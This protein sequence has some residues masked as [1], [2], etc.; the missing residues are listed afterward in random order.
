[1]ARIELPSG[2]IGAENLP[3]TKRILQNIWNNGDG[4]G[5]Q[6]PGI[7]SIL[8]TTGN[9]A[10]GIFEWNDSLYKV[11]SQELRKIT[12]VTT[13]V[14]TLVGT[15]A[16]SQPIKFAI[17]FNTATIVV[18]QSDGNI[19]TLDK[20]DVLTKIWDGV[21]ESGNSNFV[22]C[23]DLTHVDSR[24][25]YI[26][27][28]GTPAFV[29]D[30]G[31]AG[32]VQ[33]DSFFDAEELPDINNG[34]FRD[35]NNR[36][37][38]AGE[39]SIQPFTN[40]GADPVTFAT[41]SGGSIPVG[42][43]GGLLEYN[44]A[45][46]LIGREKGQDA[47][48]HAI[49]NGQSKKISNEAIDLILSTYSEARLAA[50]VTTRFKWRGY[51]IA[52]FSLDNDSFI[53][54]GGNWPITETL[55][56]GISKPW[57]LGFV[58]EFEKTY[59]SLVNDKFGKLAKV[60]TDYGERMTRIMTLG[61]EQEDGEQFTAASLELGMSQGFNSGAGSVA[62]SMSNDGLIFGEKYFIDTGN[63]GEYS[64]KM[65]W[66]FAG[67]LGTYPGFMGMELYTAEDIEMSVDYVSVQFR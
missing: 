44:Q 1:M 49:S 59:Y 65:L 50:V 55:I 33:S 61:F 42:L 41:I 54:F 5:I 15:I 62:L 24:F 36:L 51:D 3:R 11:V 6:R 21:L 22:S 63:I 8:T 45:F 29:S 38:I 18:P 57:T 28:A 26:P 34:C 66:D 12:D 14:S 9:V 31:A 19:Y 47:G 32:T 37:N 53:F 27:F 17:G 46:L 48:I 13:G 16:G 39:Q 25:T 56:N 52:H 4:K 67:G 23:I 58:E 60:N 20:S 40:T 10:R 7:S 43:I 2:L 35:H 30:V 64:N